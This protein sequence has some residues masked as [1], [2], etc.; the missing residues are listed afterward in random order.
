VDWSGWALFGLTSTAALTAVLICAQLADLTRLDLPLLLGT[1]FTEDPDHARAAGFVAHLAAGQVFALL[2]AAGFAALGTATWQWGVLFG[3]VHVGIALTALI[4]LF[5]GLNPR[6]S[7][8]RAGL[9]TRTVL[10]PPGLLALNYGYQT[11]L[12]AVVA[13]LPYG[14]MLGW[15][16][17]PR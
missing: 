10:E 2:Y 12:V 8:L 1:L 6:I 16:L 7:S 3:L 14:G 11:P 9:E 5:A 13:H 4:P 17:E 15:L